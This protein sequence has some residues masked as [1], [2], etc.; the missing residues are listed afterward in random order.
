MK[1][2]KLGHRARAL[3]VAVYLM[4]LPPLRE[5]PRGAYVGTLGTAVPA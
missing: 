4:P 1:R 2:R 3:A 5:Y